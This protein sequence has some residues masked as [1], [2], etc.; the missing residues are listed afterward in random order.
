MAAA[1]SDLDQDLRAMWKTAAA[2]REGGGGIYRAAL[3]NLVTPLDPESH[4]RFA[5]ILVDV[6]RRHPSRLLL[7][8]IGHEEEPR[9]LTG[10]VAALCHLRPAGGYVC[11]EQIVLTGGAAAGPLVP[12]AV[13]SLL[14]GNLPLILLDLRGGETASWIEEI[15]ERANLHLSDSERIRGFGTRRDLWRR[16]GEDPRGRLRDLAWSRLTPWREIVAE[17]FD[18]ARLTPALRETTEVTIE[19]GGEA[20]CSPA[21][22]LLAGWVASRLGWTAPQETSGATRFRSPAGGSATVRVSSVAG[23]PGGEVRR[24]HFRSPGGRSLDLAVDRR[25]GAS[26][27]Q[28]EVLAPARASYEVPVHERDLV[29]AIVTELQ[30]HE[31]NPILRES[32]RTAAE[33]SIQGADGGGR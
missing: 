5:S 12:S 9:E 32:A 4:R 33:I 23:A 31:P 14:V 26:S 24:V 3:A 7:V 10:E 16:I 18:A 22:P 29:S 11:S 1:I 8:E 30:R 13:R 19:T 27:A 21:A 28:V 2:S 15:G 25:E 17:A 20:P 6:T